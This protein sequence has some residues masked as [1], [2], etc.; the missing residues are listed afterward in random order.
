VTHGTSES[1]LSSRREGADRAAVEAVGLLRRWDPRL[2]L[3][4]AI[5]GAV[6]VLVTLAAWVTASV[7]ASEAE[8]HARADAQ[9]LLI[10]LATQ[11]R[12]A[13][14][15]QLETRRSLVQATA[16]Q[17]KLNGGDQANLQVQLEAVKAEFPE[18]IWLGVANARG[19]IVLATGG[20]LVGDDVSA[21]PWYGQGKVRPFVSDVQP[22]PAADNPAGA[23][24][25][26]AVA[27][28]IHVAAP[29]LGAPADAGML[30]GDLSWV[31]I[32]ELLAR[33]QQALGR[34]RPIEI[35]LADGDNTVLAGPARWHGRRIVQPA[36]LTEGGA[37][38]VGSQTHRRVADG[39][40]LGW[41]AI[42]RQRADMA[43]V[44]VEATRRTV[45][46][47]VFLAGLVS[48]ALAVLV[49]R[50]Q[51]RR[52][53][54][55]SREA[56]A[57]RR[58]ERRTLAVPPGADE[59]SRIGA[60]LAEVVEHLQR[61]KQT[62]QTLNAELDSRV[63]ARTLRI[64]RMSD[65]AR[66]AAITRERLRLARD[67]HDTLAH[68]LMALL[69]QIRLV[70]KLGG[71]L[72]AG[73][74]DAELARA[75]GVAATGLTD[76]RA[77]I[78]Q[79]RGNGVRDTGLGPALQGLLDKFCERSGVS[80]KLELDAR[81]AELASERAEVAYRVAEEAVRNVERHAEAHTVDIALQWMP[82]AAGRDGPNDADET[83]VRLVIADDGI[84][85]DTAR[86]QPGHYGLLGI[87]EQAELIDARLTLTS[88]PGHGTRIE[89]EFDV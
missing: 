78:A 87:H 57:V 27:R 25:P 4:V 88:R 15:M 43:L 71:R 74:L 29:M 34:T 3:A 76:A 19:R 65:E 12:D 59:V 37:Y 9:G 23:Q 8:R 31:W 24:T 75:E 35:M 50:W 44:P 11:V 82:A 73:E 13:L 81:A 33:I 28:V 84:G 54:A 46:L 10:E 40:G 30:V 62:L 42:V 56:E 41:T 67:L 86:P 39:V 51:L 47:I 64:A 77:A 72:G 83:R 6:F 48:A 17:L 32:E 16:A 1:R 14:A 5:G 66:Q 55:L 68:S 79:M 61:E 22:L 26:S 21:A 63:A 38:L 69:T 52:L 85:F 45:F 53:T 89:L 36:D 49:T 60:T 7:A 70:R 20:R 18:F 2:H 80:G 58:G